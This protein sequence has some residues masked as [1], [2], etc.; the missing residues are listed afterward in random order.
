MNYRF[1]KTYSQNFIDIIT[2]D[3][4][5]NITERFSFHHNAGVTTIWTIF[6]HSVQPNSWQS[7]FQRFQGFLHRLFR[8]FG[9]P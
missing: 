1:T 4:I 2:G 6:Q 9:R 8:Y 5:S 3:T 7:I